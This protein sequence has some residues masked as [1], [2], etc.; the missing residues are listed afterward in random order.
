MHSLAWRWRERPG[1]YTARAQACRA[2]LHT[3]MGE[4]GSFLPRGFLLDHQPPAAALEPSERTGDTEA[5]QEEPQ[6]G[7]RDESKC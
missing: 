6:A 5:L 2:P 1:Q 3:L 4:P 7:V